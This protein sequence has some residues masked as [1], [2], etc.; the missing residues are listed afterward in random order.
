M[1]VS[2]TRLYYKTEPRSGRAITRPCASRS[3]FIAIIKSSSIDRRERRDGNYHRHHW[4]PKPGQTSTKYRKVEE[5]RVTS[6]RRRGK[7]GKSRFDVFARYLSLSFDDVF[8]IRMEVSLSLS[9]TESCLFLVAGYIK[10]R[11]AT[12]SIFSAIRFFIIFFL[13]CNFAVARVGKWKVER[14]R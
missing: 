8:F 7:T 2:R 3:S 11:S 14:I 4:C 9:R 1:C 5:G 10:H 13:F 12:R 6:S